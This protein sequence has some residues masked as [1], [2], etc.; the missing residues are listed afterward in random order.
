MEASYTLKQTSQNYLYS[1]YVLKQRIIEWPCLEGRLWDLEKT[2]GAAAAAA[3]AS[4]QKRTRASTADWSQ[5]NI[6]GVRPE[7][8]Y[9]AKSWKEAMRWC[10]YAA[11]NERRKTMLQRPASLLQSAV[12]LWTLGDAAVR[13]RG[14]ID[15]VY[16]MLLLISSLHIS[17]TIYIYRHNMSFWVLKQSWG[18][19]SSNGEILDG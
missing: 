7:A 9:S 5:S 3:A 10:Q 18:P 16:Y 13:R 1:W 2:T 11:R 15:T 14:V 4:T 6:G 12:S 17:M 19:S 8:R